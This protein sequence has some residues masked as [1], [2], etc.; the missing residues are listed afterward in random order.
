MGKSSWNALYKHKWCVQDATAG[1]VS[2][3]QRQTSGVSLAHSQGGYQS[4]RLYTL[5]VVND[6][7]IIG[8]CVTV[9]R[10]SKLIVAWLRGR[11]GGCRLRVF[12]EV[13]G[14]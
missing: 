13:D 3:S 14:R 6:R 11:S 10:L 5:P 9:V 8:F 2:R 7:K 12:Q 1:S 4:E